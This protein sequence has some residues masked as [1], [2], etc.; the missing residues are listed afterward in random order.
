MTMN[1]GDSYEGTSGH[2]TIGA[3]GYLKTI[4]S[5]ETRIYERDESNHITRCASASA[6]AASYDGEAGFAV[7]CVAVLTTGGSA[8]TQYI[9]EGST[10]SAT[11]VAVS[12]GGSTITI[13][14]EGTDT[15]CFPVF[16][17]SSTPGAVSPK[18]NALGL[19]YNSG[20]PTLACAKFTGDIT[21]SAAGLTAGTVLPTALQ[22][23]AADLGA[24]DVTINL[25]NTNGAFNTNITT[26]GSITASSFVGAVTGNA[27]TATSAATLTT[28]RTIGGTSFNGSANIVPGTITIAETADTTCFVALF[29]TNTPGAAAPVVDTPLT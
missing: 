5:V 16:S 13:G 21:G 6:I 18:V 10:S 22:A 4:N 25:G 17:T 7:G 20:D 15:T 19:T 29:E 12:S 11:F 9:N 8:T 1:A 24:A 23:A 26:D 14:E 3:K 28:P 2:N 27:D